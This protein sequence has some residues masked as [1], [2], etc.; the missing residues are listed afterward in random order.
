MPVK[1]MLTEIVIIGSSDV[2]GNVLGYSYEDNKDSEC[3]GLDK[4]YSY[5]KACRN[6]YENVIL[7]DNGDILQGNILA[8]DIASKCEGDNPIIKAMNIMGYDAMTVG[9][10]EFNWGVSNLKRMVSSASFPILAANVVRKDGTPLFEGHAIVE[11]G[12]IRIAIIG[13]VSPNIALW[14]GGKEGIDDYQYRDA[15]IAVKEEISRI[16]DVDAYVVSAH[17][18]L[19]FEYDTENFSDSAR[20]IAEMNPEVAA[21]LIGHKHTIVNERIGNTLVAAPRNSA[22]EVVS[23]HLYF[24]SEKRIKKSRADIIKLDSIPK[25]NCLIKD[26]C[27]QSAHAKTLELI[28]SVKLGYAAE[29]FKTAGDI[30]GIPEALLKDN[31]ISDMIKSLMLKATGADIA[32]TPLFK[33]DSYFDKGDIYYYNI[34]SVYKYDNTLVTLKIT[35]KE[36]KAYMEWSAEFYNQWKPGDINISFNPERPH[37]KY[38]T[39]SG[40]EYEIDISKNEGERIVSLTRH[41]K[42]VLDEDIFTLVVNSYRYTSALKAFN[43]A[44]GKKDWESSYSVRDLIVENFVKNSPIYPTL[45]NNWRIVGVD[46]NLE[47]SRRMEIKEW[48]SM[49]KIP[50]PYAKSYNLTDYNRLKFDSKQ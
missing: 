39:F 5:V 46:L 50:V 49:G 4:I 14:D 10:H 35:G 30:K 16:A 22:E 40:V 31:P 44:S 6:K 48:I 34:F 27:V 1:N 33:P 47:D 36:L 37:Y 18:G 21:I 12:G 3:G 9:N 8:D 19:E 15:A 32:A 20:K 2:H 42:K 23:F 29:S 38:D 25:S 28:C 43:L 13:V 24:D 45:E 26:E 7:L 41:G 11:R 17:M